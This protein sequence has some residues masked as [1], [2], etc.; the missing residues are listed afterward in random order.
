MPKR[1]KQKIASLLLTIQLFFSFFSPLSPLINQALAADNTNPSEQQ[2]SDLQFSY[3]VQENQLTIDQVQADSDYSYYYFHN[4]VLQAGQGQLTADSSHQLYLGT[5][6]GQDASPHDFSQLIFKTESKAYYLLNRQDQAEVFQSFASD[7]LDLTEQDQ[8]WLDWQLD[9]DAKSATTLE[10]VE[11]EHEYRFPFN[12]RVKVVFTKL[13]SKSSQLTIRQIDLSDQLAEKYGTEVAFDITTEMA[14]GEFEFD[15]IL[16]Q[17]QKNEVDDLGEASLSQV[18]YAETE[19]ELAVDKVTKV[20]SEQT[21]D[22]VRVSQLDHM[23]V[24]I[25]TTVDPFID[26]YTVTNTDDSGDGSFR[27]AVNN[28]NANGGGTVKFDISSCTGVCQ[29]DLSS[30]VQLKGKVQVDGYTQSGALKNTNPFGGS[31]NS[32]IKIKLNFIAGSLVLRNSENIVQGVSVTGPVKAI[33]VKG[34]NKS[35]IKGSYIGV[36]PDGTCAATTPQYGVE[37]Y[38][39]SNLLVGSDLDGVEDLAEINVIGCA[40]DRGVFT[41]LAGGLTQLNYNYFGVGPGLQDVGNRMGYYL[42]RGSNPVEV[43]QNLFGFNIAYGIYQWCANNADVPG[44]RCTGSNDFLD[45]YFGITPDGVDVGNN[46]AYVSA[47][48]VRSS[49][50]GDPIKTLFQGNVFAH[51]NHGI[52]WQDGDDFTINDN[53]FYQNGIG[54]RIAGFFDRVARNGKITNNQIHNNVQG[55]RVHNDRVTGLEVHQNSFENNSTYGLFNRNYSTN[56]ADNL[57]NATNNW[58]GDSSGPTDTWSGDGSTPDTNDGSG[59]SVRGAV[60]YDTWVGQT[61]TDIDLGYETAT[62]SA[63]QDNPYGFC[64]VYTNDTSRSGKAL[65]VLRFSEVVMADQYRITGYTWNGSS[66]VAGTPYNPEEWAKTHDATFE[67]VDGVVIY[68]TGATY[69]NEYTYFVEALNNDQVIAHSQPVELE[70]RDS[71]CSFTVDRTAPAKPLMTQVLKGHGMGGSTIMSCSTDTVGYTNQ[72]QVTFDWEPVED[73][74]LSHYYFGI[75]DNPYHRQVGVNQ[76]HYYGNMTPGRNPYWYSV[77]AVDKA[78]N[79]REFVTLNANTNKAE[80]DY[81]CGNLILDQEAP[82]VTITSHN[83]GDF[84]DGQVTVEG[85]VVDANPHHYWFVVQNSSGQNIAGPG[86]VNEFNSPAYPSFTWDTTSVDEG[87]YTIKLEARDQANNKE[88]NQAPVPTDPEN[89]SDS[90][91]WVTVTVD[92]T[93]PAEPTGLQRRNVAGSKTYQCGAYA[94]RQTLIPDWDDNTESDFSHYEYSSFHPD[95]S[96]GLDE[97]RLEVSEMVHNWVPPVDGTYGYAVRAVD[98]A[99]NKSGWALTDESLEGSCQIHYDSTKPI[100]TWLHPYAGGI[101]NSSFDMSAKS[102]EIMNNFRFKW[103]LT[104]G[105]SWIKGDNLTEQKTIYDYLFDPA[106]DGLY[107]LRAQGRDLALNWNRAEDIEVTIDRTRPKGKIEQPEDGSYHSAD[108]TVSGTVSD[109]LTGVDRV[110]VRLRNHPDNTYRTPWQDADLDSQGNYSTVVSVTNVPDDDY[111]VAVVAYDKAGNN[112]WLWP[113]PVITLDRVA[114]LTEINYP[115]Q[116]DW[117]RGELN[118]QGTI[119]DDRMLSRYNIAVYPGDADYMDFS[120]RLLQDTVS[121]SSNVVDQ[122]V[123]SWNTADGNYQDGQYLIRLAARDKAGNRDLSGDPYAGGDDSQHVIEVNVDNTIP[124]STITGYGV[125]EAV[126]PIAVENFGTI[127]ISDW[128]GQIYGTASDDG[129]GVAAVNLTI[130]KD[131]GAEISYWNGV[132]WQPA[133]TSVS[134]N[135]LDQVVNWDYAVSS[136][137][138]AVYT[139]TS[140]A[141][142]VAGNQ[143]NTY[144]VT[145]VLDKTIPEVD[146]TV[147]PVDPDGDNGWYLTQ[148][149]I[150]LQATDP[151]NSGLNSLQYQWNDQEQAGWITIPAF[152]NLATVELQ[153]A[154]EG[155]NIL[156]YRAV[157]LAGNQ[158]EVDAASET[159][160]KTVSWDGTELDETD[161]NVAVDP[162]PTSGSTATVTWEDASDNVAVDHYEVH[163]DWLDGDDDHVADTASHVT[164]YQLTDLR[165]GE[166]KITVTAYDRPG[167]TRSDSVTL[168]VDQTAPTAP[169]LSLVGT[170]D[171]TVDLAW[172]QVEDAAQYIV[173]YGLESGEYLYAARVG[174][175]LDFTVEGLTA[176]SYYFVVRAEDTVGNQSNNSNEV[177]SGQVAGVFDQG[178]GGPAAGFQ[179]TGEVLGDKTKAQDGAEAEPIFN[180]ESGQVAGA[181]ITCQPVK[182]LLP[183]LLLVVQLVLLLLVEWRLRQDD[184]P[185]RYLYALGITLGSTGLFYLLRQCNCYNQ[186]TLSALVCS[187]YWLASIG[188]TVLVRLVGYSYLEK[189]KS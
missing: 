68:T 168:V 76:T 5:R 40:S 162:N 19:A 97:K 116:G 172:T 86:V 77:I 154:T 189:K 140:K 186:Q 178:T 95:G 152:E 177:A 64:D 107:T 125:E 109:S 2:T 12:Q 24:F 60:N 81:A 88:P 135:L 44:Q 180:Q 54:V 14:D 73:S 52:N 9:L 21:E 45:N 42:S 94:Q 63:D 48:N 47:G 69:E 31:L 170:G 120:Q 147:D 157:D 91:D 106:E 165:A 33:D 159:G 187:W 36:N 70:D 123:L 62:Q 58:W 108:I 46:V 20:E 13:P 166:Y 163:W 99:G 182:Q 38:W 134:A 55:V 29:I 30:S 23:T 141:E 41:Y 169:V 104:D 151:S 110:K 17:N 117:L 160:I 118:I 130:K 127:Y 43:K 78:G 155:T 10:P 27:W 80:L 115:S 175:V 136:P 93:A 133:E 161:L 82:V 102:N 101:F 121:I 137:E 100:I 173:L 85:E 156:Y 188:T 75:K 138:Q 39:P 71:A 171:G 131:T 174:N 87:V 164:E 72:T 49:E 57:V 25:V 113:R 92:R 26:L 184:S 98:N 112:K 150:T 119:T 6:S 1:Y 65:Q 144:Q 84:V 139:I 145:L 143:E 89:P 114:P 67:I 32:N 158:T 4:N 146:L 124:T 74:S 79:K 28:A 11:L 34:S 83:D 132:D 51:N 181:A 142:D 129:S 8:E 149:T 179:E 90:V 61:L 56:P 183:W 59:N 15:L 148:P 105:G 167:H 35:W 128:N 16:P 96:I 50:S 176:G 3:S 37:A 126:E 185:S 153:P 111:Q 122:E 66:W 22:E 103:R 7:N 53:Q 18:V